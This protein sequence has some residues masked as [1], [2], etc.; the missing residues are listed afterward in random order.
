MHKKENLIRFYEG[1]PKLLIRRII[2]RQNRLS[3][4]YTDKK[5]VFKKDI[6]P[7]IP[8]D[9]RFSSKY[10][11]AILASK[12]ISYLYINIS[13]IATKDDFRQTTLTELR[14]LPIII[15]DEKDESLII[16]LVDKILKLKKNT[17]SSN[18]SIIESEID[19]MVYNLYDLTDEEIKIIENSENG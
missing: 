3:V 7:F 15:P 17:K 19:K 1:T 8:I 5:L 14:E 12:L 9:K 16:D 13:S 18:T 11:L 10:L 4:G 2:N 6:N